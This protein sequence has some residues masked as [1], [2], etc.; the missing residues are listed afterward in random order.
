MD[1]HYVGQAGR[2]ICVC[3]QMRKDIKR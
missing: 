2:M 3:I 1:K